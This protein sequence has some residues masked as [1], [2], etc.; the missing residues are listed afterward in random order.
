MSTAAPTDDRFRLKDSILGAQMLFVAF[1]ALVLVP[2]L[3][4]LE[5]NVALFTAGAGHGGGIMLLLFG[6]ITVV[7]LNTLVRAGQDLL[8]AR[9]LVIVSLTLVAGF[10]GLAL[11]FGTVELRGIG[12]AG[13]VAVLLNLVL[14]GH[15]AS[16]EDGLKGP[17]V[18]H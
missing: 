16:R 7:G 3:T 13:L 1:G 12:L 15:K 10:G 17:G 5:A 8:E 14:P 11:T 4:G 18:P 2:L 9:N 6:A